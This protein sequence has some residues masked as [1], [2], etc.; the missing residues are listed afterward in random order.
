M[1]VGLSRKN[2]DYSDCHWCG[3]DLGILV[4][5]ILLDLGYLCLCVCN[6]LCEAAVQKYKTPGN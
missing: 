2:V 1:S 5:G 4:G 3:V 6:W